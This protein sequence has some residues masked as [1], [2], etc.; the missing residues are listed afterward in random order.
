MAKDKDD[1]KK[2]KS[3]K[4][5]SDGKAKVAKVLKGAK[6]RKSVV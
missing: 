3:K 1:K 5:K 2:S 6:D 4:K